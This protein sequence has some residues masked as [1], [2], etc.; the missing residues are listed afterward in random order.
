V[1]IF[2]NIYVLWIPTEIY[3]LFLLLIFTIIQA[4]A[5]V[6]SLLSSL[7]SRVYVSLNV[8]DE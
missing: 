6:L 2:E 3:K 5:Q 8:S 4:E 7:P 1:A